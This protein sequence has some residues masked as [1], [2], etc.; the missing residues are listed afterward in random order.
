MG[1][2]AV[3]INPGRKNVAGDTLWDVLM[4]PQPLPSTTSREMTGSSR[5]LR[6]SLTTLT[7]ERASML[8]IS[9][10]T[11]PELIKPRWRMIALSLALLL[12]CI[13]ATAAEAEN[14]A[15][16]AEE[17][18]RTSR[19]R[20]QK[21]RSDVQAAWQFARASFDLAEFVSDKEQRAEV[22]NQG[23]EATRRA[24]AQDPDSA[25]S[26]YYLALN[27]GQLAR[28]KNIGALKLVHEMEREFKAAIKL[29]GKLDYAGP[30]RSLGHLYRDAPGWPTSI[31]SKT[32]ARAELERAVELFPDYPGNRMALAESYAKWGE[33]RSLQAELETLKE[34][35]PK[36][37]KELTGPMWSA[38]WT[39]WDQRLEKLQRAQEKPGKRGR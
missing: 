20:Y 36:A 3:C 38:S 34:T 26:H 12:I 33:K 2:G 9:N 7:I 25:E 37:R 5:M 4:P 1:G 22:A 31:G 17:A 39:E 24:L 30:H 6:F 35:L 8:A 19:A 21:D 11:A 27:L 28:T 18:F 13:S 16:Q 15:K 29:N 32:K 10:S 14:P 23:I